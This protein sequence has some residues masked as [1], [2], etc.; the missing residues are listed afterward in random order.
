MVLQINDSGQYCILN[1]FCSTKFKNG[2]KLCL[3]VLD[4]SFCFLC[5]ISYCH[6]LF[7]AASLRWI[8]IFS[9]GTQRVLRNVFCFFDT[10][11]CN[12][13]SLISIGIKEWTMKKWWVAVVKLLEK[14]GKENNQQW[15]GSVIP[16]LNW[17]FPCQAVKS[18][19]KEREMIMFVIAAAALDTNTVLLWWEIQKRKAIWIKWGKRGIVPCKW[20]L[21]ALKSSPPPTTLNTSPTPILVFPLYFHSAHAFIPT[22][23]PLELGV[24]II[25]LDTF[26]LLCKGETYCSF[27]SLGVP[28]LDVLF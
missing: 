4:L 19:N 28:C 20:Y 5:T 6:L 24:R 21:D 14:R 7:C 22:H 3:V 27:R 12:P 13:H 2:A 17:N 11:P 23:F 15:K 26:N 9:T 16:L 1:L 10:L 8:H 18:K 25:S